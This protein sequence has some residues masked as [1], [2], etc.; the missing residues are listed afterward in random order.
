M[1]G[2]RNPQLVDEQGR[3]QLTTDRRP[4]HARDRDVAGTTQAVVKRRATGDAPCLADL[5]R[6][7][8]DPLEHVPRVGRVDL[9]RGG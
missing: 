8:L 5:S 7:I 2:H 9:I 1:D 3:D 4:T 6:E